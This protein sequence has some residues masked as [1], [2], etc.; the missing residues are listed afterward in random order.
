MT[1]PN[2]ETPPRLLTIEEVSDWTRLPVA[3]LRFKRSR[4]EG[5]P[6]LKLGRRVLYRYEAVEAWIESQAAA[7]GTTA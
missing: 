5:P 7:T 2:A 3:T 1:A 4:G 6:S